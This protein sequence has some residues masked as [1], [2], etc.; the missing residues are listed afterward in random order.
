MGQDL[1]PQGVESSA[2]RL[3]F[4]SALTKR[5][6]A[7]L[8]FKQAQ[9]KQSTATLHSLTLTSTIMSYG[10]GCKS[11]SSGGSSESS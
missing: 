11:S 9:A 7:V 10:G 8:A 1:H 3:P 2:I 6:L 4:A 5:T